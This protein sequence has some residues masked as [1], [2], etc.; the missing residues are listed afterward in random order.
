MPQRA[1]LATWPQPLL[2]RRLGLRAPCL[3]FSVVRGPERSLQHSQ[4][5]WAGGRQTGLRDPGAGPPGPQGWPCWPPPAPAAPSPLCP[6]SQ[7]MSEL[8]LPLRAPLSEEGTRILKL[9]PTWALPT[10]AAVPGQRH[11]R[12]GAA[13]SPRPAQA[14]VCWGPNTGFSPFPASP[15]SPFAA[16]VSTRTFCLAACPLPPDRPPRSTQRP[17]TRAQPLPGAPRAGLP[18]PHL[19]PT[20]LCL[21]NAHTPSHSQHTP[22]TPTQLMHTQP[23]TSQLMCTQHTHIHTPPTPNISNTP[24][25]HTH[26]PPH[27]HARG[28]S[29]Y[30]E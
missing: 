6:L 30:S 3:S 7:S 17:R 22:T 28:S 12:A 18:Q 11:H 13:R 26:T 23:H 29:Q 5:P 25:Q 21:G 15:L 8:L 20:H 16:P 14:R 9:S 2:S 4:G 1:P 19:P 27:T 10:R 24:T